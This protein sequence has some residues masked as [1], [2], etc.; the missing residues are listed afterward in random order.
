MQKTLLFLAVGLALAPVRLS[1]QSPKLPL[2]TALSWEVYPRALPALQW[3]ADDDAYSHLNETYSELYRIQAKT[4]KR[5]TVFTLADFRTLTGD[6]AAGYFV[7]A[8]WTGR[9]ELLFDHQNT[10]FAYNVKNKKSEKRLSYPPEAEHTD[11]FYAKSR[12]AYTLGNNLYIATEKDPKIAVTAHASK[13][14]VAGQSIARSEFGISKGTF[15][16]PEGNFLAFYEKDESQV[17]DYTLLDIN[18]VPLQAK[19]IKYPMTGQGSEYARVGVFDVKSRKTVYLKTDAAQRDQ[20]LTNLGWSPD[21]KSVYVAVV[22]REQNRMTLNRY[23]ART[24]DLEKTLFEES[25]AR[26]VEPEHAVWFAPGSKGEEFY[27]ASERDGFMHLYRYSADGQLL[28]QVTKGNWVVLEMLGLRDK[29]K[30]LVVKGTDESGLN[31]YAYSVRLSDGQITRLTAAEGIHQPQL[32]AD[33]NWLL[34]TYS[35]P[36]T[37]SQSQLI[38]T[39]SARIEATL[40]TAADPLKP[41]ARPAIEAVDLKADDGTV[42]HGRLIKPSDFNPSRKYPVLIYVYG[43]PHAQMVSNEW[44]YGAEPWMLAFAER[45]HLVFTLDN[46]GSANRGFEFESVIHRR[47]GTVELSDQLKGVEYLANQPF[48]DA[49]RI[50]VHGWSFGGFM[51]LTLLLRAPERFRVGVAGG[52]VTDWKFY[53]VMYG[54][55]YMDTPQENPDGYQQSSIMSHVQALRADLLVVHGAMDDVVVPQHT[56][57]LMQAFINAGK[58]NVDFFF[59]PNQKHGVGGTERTHLYQKMLEFIEKAFK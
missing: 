49:G 15:W 34:D 51:T 55:R 23:N 22:N 39:A 30:E 28:G 52:A 14:I 17:T 11:A 43:G 24:G 41:Y 37:P 21:E 10:W 29:G 54:E 46:R 53:E 13:Q 7:P 48:V 31:V 47:L 2:E 9:E 35:N 4:Q 3:V 59:Y 57:A 5:E 40:H 36:K 33:G 56:Y 26:Y 12:M 32:S 27:W 42:L 44:L 19:V 45:G 16:S 18:S 6:A 1:G 20:Y 58:R 8:A 25:H 50:G 38:Q